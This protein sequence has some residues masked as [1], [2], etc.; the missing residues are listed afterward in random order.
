MYLCMHACTH[1]C[2]YVGD[3]GE[4]RN[5]G[6]ERERAGEMCINVKCQTGMTIV[7]EGVC[8]DTSVGKFTHGI[9]AQQPYSTVQLYPARARTRTHAHAHTQPPT[10]NGRRATES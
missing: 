7:L 9:D 4:E 3:C 1:F 8:P 5:K 10:A 2:L 6:A